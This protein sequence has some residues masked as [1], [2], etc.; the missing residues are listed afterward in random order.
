MAITLSTQFPV[1]DNSLGPFQQCIGRFEIYFNPQHEV[2]ELNYLSM[3]S[4]RVYLKDYCCE[5]AGFYRV[6]EM[7]LH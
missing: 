2:P 1:F 5:T 4:N 6:C 3:I 7:N